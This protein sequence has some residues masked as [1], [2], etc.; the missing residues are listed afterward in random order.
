RRI[1]HDRAVAIKVLRQRFEGSYDRIEPKGETGITFPGIARVSRGAGEVAERAGIKGIGET[2][3]AFPSLSRARQQGQR[4][5]R[6]NP[7]SH[8][9]LPRRLFADALEPL[10]F[11]DHLD[12]EILR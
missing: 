1:R 12:A 8:M 11:G 7:V 3:A 5:T 4:Q 2:V 10:V 6:A 9:P